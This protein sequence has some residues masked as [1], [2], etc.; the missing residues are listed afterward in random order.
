MS[1]NV[2]KCPL[3]S[4]NLRVI[5]KYREIAS[6]PPYFPSRSTVGRFVLSLNSEER[7]GKMSN[8]AVIDIGKIKDELKSIKNASETV[9]QKTMTDTKKRGPGW[10]GKGVSQEYNIKSKDVTGGK[11]AKLKVKGDAVKTLAFEFSGRML[12]PTHFKMTPTAPPPGA[13]T[14]KATIKKGKRTTI[15][16]IKK[17]TKKQRQNIG[18]NFRRQGTRNSP[19]SPPMLAST[20]NK[21]EGG[22][23]FI[24]FQRTKQPGSLDRAIRTISVPQMI[25][26]GKGQTKPAVSAEI[27]INMQKRFEH[28][29]K[30]YLG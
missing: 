21:R 22:V 26:D 20:G 29:L 19:S 16:K 6:K 18:R 8:N 12:T 5:Y 30:R 25:Q 27:N 1:V 23:N 13:Y 28:Y 11:L 9:I 15:G 14:I 2:R 4:V 17:L 10:I 7:G 3:M 24:P